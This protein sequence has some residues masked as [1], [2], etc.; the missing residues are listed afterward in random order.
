MLKKNG[1]VTL[2]EVNSAVYDILTPARKGDAIRLITA[3]IS[4]SEAPADQ[5]QV[6]QDSHPDDL[7]P[8]G[9]A[10]VDEAFRNYRDVLLLFYRVIRLLSRKPANQRYIK[11]P[12]AAA[13]VTSLE[14]ACALQ[15]SDA[16]HELCAAISNFCANKS[17]SH[18]LTKSVSTLL[19]CL[20]LRN[21][22][23]Q[24]VAAGALQALCMSNEG[25]S[26]CLDHDAVPILCDTLKAAD[27]KGARFETVV[28][29]C[30]GALHNLSS[31][32]SAP[33]R[34]LRADAETVLVACLSHRSPAVKAFA[35]GALQALTRDKACLARLNELDVSRPL[36]DLVQCDDTSV[37]TAAIGAL[38]NLHGSAADDSE[39]RA[40][41]K[42]LLSLLV[43]TSALRDS[44][45]T[46]PATDEPAPPVSPHSIVRT[47]PSPIPSIDVPDAFFS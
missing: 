10:I 13:I 1:A 12:L 14:S 27:R 46:T 18:D 21:P 15:D 16:C 11:P 40:H 5:D 31:H 29:G 39:S 37:Q 30:A 32:L 6:Q 35:A 8:L 34:Y 9:A 19:A 45:S 7:A 44:Y 41:L 2:D 43:T 23:L 4:Q 38:L 28:V 33:D 25:K 22:A 17:L 20:R 26:E 47:T 36:I 3:F 24:T 42:Q